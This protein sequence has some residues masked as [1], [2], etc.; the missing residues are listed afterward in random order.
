M[1]GLMTD[2]EFGQAIQ[3]AKGLKTQKDQREA[4]ARAVLAYIKGRGFNFTPHQYLALL[5]FAGMEAEAGKLEADI[6]SGEARKHF[7][8]VE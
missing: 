4:F 5:Q 6:A 2:P 3:D 8:R 1:Y 7:S